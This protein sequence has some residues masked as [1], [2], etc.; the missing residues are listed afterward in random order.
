MGS[1]RPAIRT[2]I[3]DNVSYSSMKLPPRSDFVWS[4]PTSSTESRS[5]LSRISYAQDRIEQLHSPA[6]E[7][8][9]LLSARPSLAVIRCSIGQANSSVGQFTPLLPLPP[10]ICFPSLRVPP[11][12][13]TYAIDSLQQ[14]DAL[15]NPKRPS[16]SEDD[17]VSPVTRSFL[18]V[19]ASK[20]RPESSVYSRD[21]SGDGKDLI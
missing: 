11:P 17:V 1:K 4:S 16:V 13:T 9:A 19:I 2:S 15:H 3:D 5:P 8:R 20:K 14:G 12:H 18:A 6:L 21:V 7:R 10:P